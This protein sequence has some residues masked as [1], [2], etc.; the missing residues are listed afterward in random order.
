MRAADSVLDE[1]DDSFRPE[2]PGDGQRELITVQEYQPL[3]LPLERLMVSG[4][5]QLYDEIGA[6]RFLRAYI[7]A[8][9]LVLT[10]SKYVGYVPL[11]DTIALNVQPRFPIANLTRVLRIANHVPEALENFTRGYHEDT[12][13]VASVL[14]R[15]TMAF[16]SAVKEVL[17]GGLYQDYRLFTETTSFPKGSI[18]HGRTLARHHSRGA[19]HRVDA[20]WFSRGPNN[21]INRLLK[22][23]LWFIDQRYSGLQDRAGKLRVRSEVN[24]LYRGFDGVELDRRQTFLEDPLVAQP[25]RVP[26]SRSY[27]LDALHIALLLLRNRGINLTVHSGSVRIPSL[28]INMENAFEAYLRN[29]LEERFAVAAPELRVKDGNRGGASGARKPLFDHQKSVPA[30]PDIVVEGAEQ[31]WP[32]V[33]VEVK[34]KEVKAGPDREDINQILGYGM[35]YRTTN[36]VLAYPLRPG[37]AGGLQL[38]GRIDSTEVYSYAFDLNGD[39]EREEALLARSIGRLAGVP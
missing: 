38:I 6:S 10:A 16:L 18:L 39:L 29:V 34:Y 32:R 25:S 22:Y 33:V 31:S 21:G 13:V 27:Y 36:L 17:K 37:G 3:G 19:R 11:N 24:R 30:T 23:C 4:R 7:T 12:E 2:D 35:S 1:P 14:D 8:G 9:Q 15:L 20:Q 28:L 26:H 5:F